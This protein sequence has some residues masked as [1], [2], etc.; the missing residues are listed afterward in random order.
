MIC[1]QVE[2]NG[3]KICTAGVGDFGVLTT[4]VSFV[5]NRKQN[6]PAPDGAG[7]V[8]L[9]VSGTASLSD[10]VEENVNW[11]GST[12]NV[13]D[14][15]RITLVDAIQA[16]EPVQRTTRDPVLELERTKAHYEWLIS[17]FEKEIRARGRL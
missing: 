1:F 12:L 16:D 17:E 2:I 4:V 10:G 9:D 13:G 11:A 6:R 7:Q 15:I 14:E 5:R 3:K 8:K